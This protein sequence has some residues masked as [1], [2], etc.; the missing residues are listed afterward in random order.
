MI[1]SVWLSKLLQKIL[2]EPGNVLFVSHNNVRKIFSAEEDLIIF[3]NRTAAEV[4]VCIRVRIPQEEPEPESDG[5]GDSDSYAGK[6][7][8]RQMSLF[9]F[10]D[11]DKDDGGDDE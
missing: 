9:D 4:R 5:N 1:Q 6:G 8:S 10:L 3:Q 7:E 2:N 11:D